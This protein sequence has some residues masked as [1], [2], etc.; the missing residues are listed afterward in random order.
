MVHIRKSSAGTNSYV[1]WNLHSLHNCS[2]HNTGKV[3]SRR[4]KSRLAPQPRAAG[5]ATALS[6]LHLRQAASGKLVLL[7]AT[8]WYLVRAD[9]H[10]PLGKPLLQQIKKNKIC[11][12]PF[13]Y[14]VA[15]KKKKMYGKCHELLLPNIF[16]ELY[17]KNTGPFTAILCISL[18]IAIA[19]CS[20]HRLEKINKQIFFSGES[21]SFYMKIGTSGARFLDNCLHSTTQAIQIMFILA[22]NHH[23]AIALVQWMPGFSGCRFTL[24]SLKQEMK[25]RLGMFWGH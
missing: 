6:S 19:F 5:G 1:R 16:E 20:S 22:A 9:L 25:K 21:L 18:G 14:V 15:K 13:I 24:I 8:S 3:T 17:G 4:E 7:G 12:F 23:K 11:H 2:L 10:L